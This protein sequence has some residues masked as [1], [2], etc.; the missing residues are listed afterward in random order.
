MKLSQ[1]QIRALFDYDAETGFLYWKSRDRSMFVS[2]RAFN[3]WRARYEGKQAFTFLCKGYLTGRLFAK[4]QSAHRVVWCWHHGEWPEQIDHI[5]GVRQDNR[6]ENLRAADAVL[7]AKNMRRSNRN[8]SGIL[9]VSWS[10][11]DKKWVAQ[12]RA[13]GRMMWLGAFREKEDAAAARARASEKYGFHKNHGRSDL[14]IP[15]PQPK[16]KQES[17]I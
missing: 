3:I 1:E 14:F 6:I 13:E 5:N 10:R 17:L 12:I 9:G 16:P 15:A 11:R 7:N 2:D 4:H 8:T